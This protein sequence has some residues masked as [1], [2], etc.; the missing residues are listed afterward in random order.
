VAAMYGFDLD[1]AE[2]S[3]AP[4]QG[5]LG[6]GGMAGVVQAGSFGPAR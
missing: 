6:D 2:E 3:T 1:Q 4:C 5:I